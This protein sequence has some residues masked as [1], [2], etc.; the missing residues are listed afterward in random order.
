MNS[1][2]IS[3]GVLVNLENKKVTLDKKVISS[4]Y[5]VLEIWNKVFE[6]LP[7]KEDI[8]SI[9]KNNSELMNDLNFNNLIQE[10]KKHL[11]NQ[12]FDL[13]LKD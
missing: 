4:T 10:F 6:V 11:L 9:L 12:D 13:I 7:K 1:I 2:A 3:Q 8:N 5:L